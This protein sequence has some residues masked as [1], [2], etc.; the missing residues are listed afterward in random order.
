MP[1]PYLDAPHPQEVKA[2]IPLSPSLAHHL[3]R[4]S[5]IFV[6]YVISEARKVQEAGDL[7][8]L[9]V[10]LEEVDL[11]A[12]DIPTRNLEDLLAQ[13]HVVKAFRKLQHYTTQACSATATWPDRSARE[14]VEAILTLTKSARI[15]SVSSLG[16]GDEISL[17]HL[18]ESHGQELHTVALMALRLANASEVEKL[19][20]KKELQQCLPPANSLPELNFYK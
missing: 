15:S 7:E 1:D 9:A 14:V 6:P 11:P 3:E 13:A 2:L 8:R 4:T 10:S 5:A 18:I 16:W 19:T 17:T 20:W 12:K